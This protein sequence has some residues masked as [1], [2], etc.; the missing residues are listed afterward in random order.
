MLNDGSAEESAGIA[1]DI[2]EQLRAT[3]H[4]SGEVRN[5]RKDGTPFFT[6]A[7]VSALDIAGKKCWIAVQ[8][9]ITERQQVEE[10]LRQSEASYRIVTEGSLAGVYLI[11][12][13]K[14]RYVNPVLAQALGYT[15]DE[16]IDRLGPSDLLDPEDRD[17]ILGVVERRL[18]GEGVPSRS[19]FKARCKDGSVI[20][21]ETLSRQVEYHGRPAVMGTF[22]DVTERRLAEEALK[23]SEAN[24]RTIFSAV[25]DAIVVMDP[26]TGN[27]LEVNQKYLRW[28][29]TMRRK[30]RRSAWRKCAVPI[31]LSRFRTRQELMRKALDGRAAAL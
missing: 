19:N 28:L 15:P 7:R 24:Y 30:P 8:E 23:A 26:E 20:H 17:R 9:D 18:A 5:R 31:L 27:F 25:N 2:I 21:V 16:L 1:R 14:F 29:V 11:Q 22:L 4:W 10:A 13:G 12:D 3:G 6:H